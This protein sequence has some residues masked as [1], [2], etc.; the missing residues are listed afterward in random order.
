MERHWRMGWFTR[1]NIYTPRL[2]DDARMAQ[3]ARQNTVC[4]DN[5]ARRYRLETA[6]TLWDDFADPV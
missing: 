3:E 1:T 4:I 5:D 2:S 6:R